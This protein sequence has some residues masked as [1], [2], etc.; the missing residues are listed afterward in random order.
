MLAGGHTR[1]TV[2]ATPDGHG[3]CIRRIRENDHIF[4]VKPLEREMTLGE[5][6]KQL[7]R[8]KTIKDPD[9]TTFAFSKKGLSES[10][11]DHSP[12]S[13]PDDCVVYYSHQNDC[14][15]YE[16]SNLWQ[17]GIFPPSIDWAEEAFGTG[18]PDAVNLWIGNMSSVS[19]MHKDHYENLFYVLSGEKVFTLCPPADALFLYEQ[20]VP[21]GCFAYRDGEWM[22]RPEL[23]EDGRPCAVK[24]IVANPLSKGHDLHHD[25]Y[26]LLE[27]THPIKVRVQAGD[28]LYI[29]SLWFHSVTQSCETVGVN[30]WYDMRFD[31]RWCYFHFL[32]QL[33][34]C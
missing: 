13:L 4:F 12:T 34:S 29:P 28:L 1:I 15:R 2:D 23:E 14:L 19:S 22:V 17:S 31:Q 21:S 10:S 11:P 20:D 9:D 30:Y 24:W 26:P 6:S 7:R 33:Q 27:Y 18:A 8:N 3:D 5:F 16:L 25:D 32:Q